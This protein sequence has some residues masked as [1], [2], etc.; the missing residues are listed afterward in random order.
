MIGSGGRPPIGHNLLL[1]L[2]VLFPVLPK[3]YKT[4]LQT[5]RDLNVQLPNES[6]LWYKGLKANLNNMLLT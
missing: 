4:L 3:S 5:P 2:K 6:Q 1:K